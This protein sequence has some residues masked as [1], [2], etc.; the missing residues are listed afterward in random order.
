MHMKW[1]RSYEMCTDSERRTWLENMR[2]FRVERRIRV[3]YEGSRYDDPALKWTQSSFV[4]PQMMVHDRYFYDVDTHRYTVERYLE[5]LQARYGGIDSV[6][7]WPTYPNM[8]IDDRNQHDLIRSMPGGLAGVRQMVADFH[9]R[10]VRVFFP[11]MMW[12]QGTGKPVDNW[13]AA[14]A[15]LMQEIDADGINGDTQDGVPRAFPEAARALGHPLAFEPEGA[16]HDEQLADDLL[17]WAYYEFP[18]VPAVDKWK[19]LES[20]HMVHISDRWNKDKADDLQFAFFNGVGWESWENVWGFW[21][22]ITARD[23]EAIRRVFAIE[24]AVAPFLISDRWEPYAPMLQYGVFASAW[25]LAGETVW[26]IVNRNDYDVAGPQ[27]QVVEGGVRYF[28]LYHG[29]ELTPRRLADQQFLTFD[30]EAH[31]F[32]AVLATR[33]EPSATLLQLMSRTKAMSAR[34]LSSFPKDWRPL[35]QRLQGSP[36]IQPAAAQPAGM[37]RIPAAD[38]EFK[39]NGVE[40][41]GAELTGIDVQYPWESTPRLFHDHVIHVESFWID[42]YPVTN[43]Q[44]KKFLDETHYAPGNPLNFLRDWVN[45]SYPSGWENRPVTWVSR[46]DAAAY[47]KWAGKRL[48]HEW[49]WQYAAQGTDGRLYPWGDTWDPSYVPIADQGR[50]MRGPDDVTSHPRGASR[51]GVEDLV[52]NV[53]QWTD[54]F[55]DEHTRSAVLRG[56]SYYRPQHSLWYFPQAYQLNQHG[57]FLL[58]A[59][60]MDRSGAIG[61]RCVVEAP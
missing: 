17:N 18:F 31:G 21:N 8:G 45:G 6:L 50:T 40:I 61:F 24:R 14:I 5:D 1:A 28:D 29:V 52:G 30:I 48:P 3:G 16:G 2:Q 11:M 58:M 55:T 59:P 38:F 27:M 19:W 54:E 32:G 13:P 37:V 35:P 43:A 9:K 51:F 53:W 10:G 7:I 47:A 46:E 12:D 15:R 39:V 23:G 20:R 57:K 41:E 44:F 49:E 4:Q 33:S 60:S 56:G 26:T 25:P 36:R 34:P 22:G 42:K